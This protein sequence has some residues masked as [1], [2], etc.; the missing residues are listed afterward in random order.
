MAVQAVM[1]Q[2][3]NTASSRVSRR[4]VHTDG[5]SGV[6]ARCASGS[7]VRASPLRAA[8]SAPL[9]YAV[10]GRAASAETGA[11]GWRPSRKHLHGKGTTEVSRTEDAA[12]LLRYVN[13]ISC[14]ICGSKTNR[15]SFFLMPVS[16]NPL[17]HWRTIWPA[18]ARPVRPAPPP[19][20]RAKRNRPDRRK[21]YTRD[22][23][24]LLPRDTIS[25]T[26]K[27]L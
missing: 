6:S 14:A 10:H 23:G 24:E 22:T 7:S 15:L 26:R 27:D 5:Q 20:S 19:D 1:H 11:K 4:T 18:R 2:L 25:G 13:K 3:H 12:N 16:G 9:S 21:S 17:L 8:V